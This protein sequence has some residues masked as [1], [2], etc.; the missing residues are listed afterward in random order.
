MIYAILFNSPPISQLVTNIHILFF[1]FLSVSQG[2]QVAVKG[3]EL[4]T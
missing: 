4:L 3:C 1:F 2:G